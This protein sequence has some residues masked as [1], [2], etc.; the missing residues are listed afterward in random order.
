MPCFQNLRS[1]CFAFGEGPMNLRGICLTFLVMQAAFGWSWPCTQWESSESWRGLSC[2][3]LG[4][5]SFPVL[6][7][8]FSGPLLCTLLVLC[9]DG[10]DFLFP[11]RSP[12]VPFRSIPF[13]SLPFLSLPSDIGHSLPASEDPVCL[14]GISPSSLVLHS[15]SCCI[16]F[17][18]LS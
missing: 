10:K 16:H 18:R 9:W 12:P 15:V 17:M 14:K 4:D 3:L 11:L 13:P 1:F 2:V 8:T 7:L 6:S 5:L